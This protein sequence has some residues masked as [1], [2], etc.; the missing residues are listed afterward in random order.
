[1]NT[2][3]EHLPKRAKTAALR[4]VQVCFHSANYYI[5]ITHIPHKVNIRKTIF[6]LIWL[7]FSWKRGNRPKNRKFCPSDSPLY[8]RGNER[9]RR[10]INS[11]SNSTC[12]PL[13]GMLSRETGKC[14]RWNGENVAKRQKGRVRRVGEGGRRSLTER[15]RPP[16]RRSGFCKRSKQK[17]REVLRSDFFARISILCVINLYRLGFASLSETLS[18]K[19]KARKESEKS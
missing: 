4:Q 9:K 5:I 10:A 8:K 16:P 3:S 13:W 19:G 17:P 15:G 14:P 11:K 1:M 12:F 6:F 7:N 18:P 2:S